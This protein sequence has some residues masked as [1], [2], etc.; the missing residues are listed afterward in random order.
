[1]EWSVVRAVLILSHDHD[2]HTHV[3]RVMAGGLLKRTDAN[4]APVTFLQGGRDGCGYDFA[5]RDY[6][7]CGRPLDRGTAKVLNLAR[8]GKSNLSRSLMATTQCRSGCYL[9]RTLSSWAFCL[10]S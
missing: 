4:S 7:N 9:T 2:C 3:M 8:S 1:M 6:C 10:R 5:R